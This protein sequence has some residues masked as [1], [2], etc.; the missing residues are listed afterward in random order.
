[1]CKSTFFSDMENIKSKTCHGKVPLNEAMAILKCMHF[2]RFFRYG[3][4]GFHPVSYLS[5]ADCYPGFC[6]FNQIEVKISFNWTVSL[7]QTPTQRPFS[8]KSI[9]YG[10]VYDEALNAFSSLHFPVY[11]MIPIWLLGWMMTDDYIIF[12]RVRIGFKL[13]FRW[14]LDIW[15]LLSFDQVLLLYS[16]RV[17]CR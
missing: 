1:M 9:R 11:S 6:T 3:S 13:W 16:A 8:R 5:T 2:K 14:K 4:L 17:G 7:Q 12:S 10:R 15:V